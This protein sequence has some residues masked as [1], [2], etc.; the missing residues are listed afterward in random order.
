MKH[1][2][3]FL[4]IFSAIILK[5]NCDNEKIIVQM[6]VKTLEYVLNYV[7]AMHQISREVPL[8]YPIVDTSQS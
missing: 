2:I 7:K 6:F 8:N 3:L 5:Y 4:F 1:L